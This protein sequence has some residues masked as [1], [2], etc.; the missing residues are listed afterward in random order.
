MNTVTLNK[1]TDLIE[2]RFEFS[3][4]LV[5][6]IKTIPDS[7]FKKQAKKHDPCW[8]IPATQFHAEHV[9]NKFG[10]NGFIVDR[11][12]RILAYGDNVVI[13]DVT[14]MEG[15]RNFQETGVSFINQ[16]NGRCIVADDMG[17][18]KTIETLGWMNFKHK[19]LNK[20]LVVTPATV[21]GKWDEEIK[22]WLG[23]PTT[24][25]DKTKGDIQPARVYI[26]SYDIMRRRY[27]DL[28]DYNW[29]LIVFDECH[30]LKNYKAQR[31]KVG[32]ALGKD[33][34]YILGL[35]G[36]P[37]LNRPSEMFTLLNMIDPV[38]WP[39][40]WDYAKRYCNL[41]DTGFGWDASGLSN[42]NELRDRLSHIMIRR[43]KRDVLDELPELTR[44]IIPVN[45][46]GSTEYKK[47]V[48]DLRKSYSGTV[49]QHVIVKVNMLRQAAGLA[50]VGAGIKWAKN[51]MQSTDEKLIIFAHHKEVVKELVAGLHQY[52]VTTIT[53]S[54]TR[55]QRDKRRKDFQEQDSPRIIIITSAG[56]EGIDLHRAS[57]I[58]FVE[59]QWT[60]SVEEQAESR[61]HRMGQHSPVTAWYLRG[62]VSIERKIHDLIESKRGMFD[63]VLGLD[64][65]ETNI[66]KE[67]LDSL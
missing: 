15:L 14:F 56:R 33:A 38:A 17:L 49:N 27:Q 23:W 7:K 43:T 54:T 9:V 10:D 18:G 6:D 35:S 41:H 2:V 30:Y 29:D 22:D 55:K 46:Q 42:A 39:K 4:D 52:G 51:M 60:P 63:D 47:I 5:D 28:R 58:L 66:I 53:G 37:F 59:R 19:D 67:F 34:R 3:W 61:A 13:S 44:S 62:D 24:I 11:E 1:S 48:K 26:M 45:M 16:T 65:I 57:N 32:L 31:T 40:W 12:V 25:V 50:K 8:F 64:E 21:V 20:V 36:T